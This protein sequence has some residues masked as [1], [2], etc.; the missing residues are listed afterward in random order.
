MILYTGGGNDATVVVVVVVVMTPPF[1]LFFS[2]K[3]HTKTNDNIIYTPDYN[4]ISCAAILPY[5][6]I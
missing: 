1:L 3:T 2:K 4:M 5:S 6:R